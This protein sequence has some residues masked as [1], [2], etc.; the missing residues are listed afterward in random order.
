MQCRL[1][2]A[3]ALDAADETAWRD[4]AGR[5]VDPN[6]MSEPECVLAAARHL[7]YG[8]DIQVLLAEEGGVLHGACPVRRVPRWNRFPLP[9]ATTDIR[10]MT[11]L[12]TPLL[13]DHGVDAARAM[14]Q[15]VSERRRHDRWWFLVVRWVGDGQAAVMVGEAASGLGFPV[16]TIEDFEQ[17]FLV[18]RSDAQYG[19]H[20]SKRHLSDYRRRARRLEELLGSDLKL[21]DRG[22][23]PSA[24]DEYIELEAAGYKSEIGVAMTTQPGESE[25]F[26]DMCAGFA[27]QDRLH[28]LSLEGGG[29]TVAMQ[30]SLE[31]GNGLFLIKVG[32]DEEFAKFDPGVQLHLRAME[33]FHHTTPAEWLDVCTFPDNEFLLRLYPDRR[34]T[35]TMRVG[36]GGWLS[37]SVALALPHVRRFSGQPSPPPATAA[38][39]AVTTA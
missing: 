12:G 34:R 19:A 1:V 9:V 7:P 10:R 28:V 11:Y 15:A 39:T 23:D 38:T 8:Q 26:R 14:L 37:R 2:R 27:R 18:R 33:F 29:R 31:A 16:E 35:I 3:V 4:L 21:V 6:P 17:P 30:I 32:H 5:A 36:L 24:V 22:R 25:Y 20:Q 13:D